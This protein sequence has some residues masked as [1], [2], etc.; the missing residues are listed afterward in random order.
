MSGDVGQEHAEFGVL[1]VGGIGKQRPGSTVIAFAAALHRWLFWWN[2]GTSLSESPS[3]VLYD[4]VLS[5]ALSGDEGPAHVTLDLDRPEF[6]ID[7][8]QGR[9]LLAESSWA[10]VSVVPRFVNLVHWIWKVSTCLLVLQFVIPM[11]RH[12]RLAK[13]NPA[14]CPPDMDDTDPAPLYRRLVVVPSYLILMGL[15]AIFSVLASVVLFAVAIAALLPIPRIDLAVHWV[16]VKLSSVLGDTYLLEHCPVEFAA[17]RSQVAHDLSWLQDHCTKV[18]VVG[19]SQGAAIAHQVLRDGGY[20]PASLRAFITL[21]QG[22]AQMHLLQAM[23]WNPDVRKN[24]WWARW[25][26]AI[27]LL[28]AGLPALGWVVRRLA[29]VTFLSVWPTVVIS[30]LVGFLLIL[31]GI[32]R[33][34]EVLDNKKNKC[35]NQMPL[36]I[37]NPDFLWTDYYASADPVSNGPF[38]ETPNQDPLPQP[39]P[40]SRKTC[41][42]VYYAGSPLTDHN[43]YLRNRDQL[44]PGLLNAL[45]AAA[46]GDGR[47]E[48]VGLPLVDEKCIRDA[49]TRR[50]RLARFMVVARLLTPPLAVVAWVFISARLLQGPMNQLTHL[51]DPHAQ[52]SHSLVHLI[53]AVLITV[54]A[55]LVLAFIPWKIIEYL[56]ERHFFGTA[57]RD[58]SESATG[59]SPGK[60]NKG[61]R[62]SSVPE[63]AR[64]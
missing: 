36:C 53:T 41:T 17:M 39:I 49:M 26:V 38:Q 15:A 42:E 10:E 18:A 45:A 34:I 46:Y 16:V 6:K 52:M 33:A 25:L 13:V 64:T 5:P 55:Y 62:S 8:R 59:E 32:A 56:N 2:N 28:V 23:D 7:G 24:A 31:L 43:S 54:A 50:R 35:Y 30:I 48:A 44:L 3:P 20:R 11:R 61:A 37:D 57:K 9:W 12:W 27:G 22:I 19:H 51:A 60:I 58:P 29:N 4:A 63:S 40:E 1:F 47:G 14:H 21:G